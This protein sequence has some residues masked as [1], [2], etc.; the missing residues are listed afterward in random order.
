MFVFVD[1]TG[2]TGANLFDNEQPVFTYGAL[3]TRDDF[4]LTYNEKLSKIAGEIGQTS[5][6]ASVQ[7]IRTIESLAPRLLEILGDAGACVSISRVVKYDL[8]VMKL[9]D[10]FFDSGENM[11]VPWHVYNAQPLR[12]LIVVQVARLLDANLV[13]RFWDAYTEQ[14]KQK[15]RS[16]MLPV[17]YH[18]ILRVNEIQDDRSREIITEA[19]NWATANPEA[20]SFH[21]GSQA[22]RKG[23]LPNMAAFPELLGS[24]EIYSKKWSQPVEEIRHDRQNQFEGKL[25]EWHAMF[26]SASA[27]PLMLLFAEK[28]VFRRVFGSKFTVCNSS[29]SWGIQVLDIILW[30]IRQIESGKQLPTNCL[31]LLS[32]CASTGY[33]YELSLRSVEL[34][35]MDSLARLQ[36]TP[37]TRSSKRAA[38]KQLKFAEK[39]RRQNMLD[40]ER[41]KKE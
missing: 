9:A 7:G 11:A 33:T 37:V 26:S 27:D 6:H 40:F 15:S 19:L 29:D 14:N 22:L 31:K 12:L 20:I 25:R 34:S 39:R 23:D 16:K 10:T 13:R 35:L 38:E 4:D 5:F 21:T 2:N 36:S 28:H 8:A 17:L 1:E 41:R 24:I 30:L 3:M 18:I 32:Y